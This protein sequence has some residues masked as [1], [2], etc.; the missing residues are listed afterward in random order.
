MGANR[1]GGV[2]LD[3][4]EFGVFQ[5]LSHYVFGA[6]RATDIAPANE[7]NGLYFCGR[8][9]HWAIRGEKRVVYCSRAIFLGCWGVL[10]IAVAMKSN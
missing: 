8:L 9:D 5:A 7:E 3:R 4:A 6:G 1:T 2:A 10:S